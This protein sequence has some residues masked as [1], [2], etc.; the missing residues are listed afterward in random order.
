MPA[1][2]A[3]LAKD[4]SVI[5]RETMIRVLM[6]G[7]SY[8]PR[9]H[10]PRRQHSRSRVQRR[11]RGRPSPVRR[12]PASPT[13][14]RRGF[15]SATGRWPDWPAVPARW[16]VRRVRALPVRPH[17]RPHRRPPPFHRPACHRLTPRHQCRYRTVLLVLT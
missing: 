2:G 7:Q 8:L 13:S 6:E 17:R 4:I 14:P 9:H 16:R 15:R 11:R 10:S 1:V 3:A 5:A 12:R